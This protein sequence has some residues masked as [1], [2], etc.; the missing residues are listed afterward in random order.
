MAGSDTANRAYQLLAVLLT[1]TAVA[2]T[3]VR[4]LAP[5]RGGRP[6]MVE[7]HSIG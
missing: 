3:V 7:R 1:L 5:P 2:A 4:I 6:A